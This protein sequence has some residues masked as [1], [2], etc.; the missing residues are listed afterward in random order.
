MLVLFSIGSLALAGLK[1][2]IPSI[3]FKPYASV[4]ANMVRLLAHSAMLE[5]GRQTR[6]FKTSPVRF[7]DPYSRVVVND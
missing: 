2:R 4:I 7:A 6:S 5:E 3:P 1:P